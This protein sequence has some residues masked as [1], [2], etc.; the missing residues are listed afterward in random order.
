MGVPKR[1]VCN[2]AG[3]GSHRIQSATVA[4]IMREARYS[5]ETTH[6]LD[7]ERPEKRLS[8][9]GAICVA[10]HRECP[11][12]RCPGKD[13]I[14]TGAGQELVEIEKGG[15]I[16]QFGMRERKRSFIGVVRRNIEEF[17]DH[18][19]RRVDRF[20]SGR[21]QV[22][23][24]H[25]VLGLLGINSVSDEDLIAEFKRCIR[26]SGAF[27]I[28]QVMHDSFDSNTSIDSFGLQVIR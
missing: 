19:Q 7:G 20:Q 10:G 24:R 17:C 9:I 5:P 14:G 11:G 8:Y 15:T 28:G 12:R 16:A 27:W 3:N 4:T 25:I 23:E 6:T 21:K 2:S 1:G 13:G 22:F 18:R 26:V